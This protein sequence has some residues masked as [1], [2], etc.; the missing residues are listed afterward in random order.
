[1]SSLVRK[2]KATALFVS[3]LP[4]LIAVA[5][6]SALMLVSSVAAVPL[7]AFAQQSPAPA[8]ANATAAT[9]T[10]TTGTLNLKQ[11]AREFLNN[12][13]NTT[14]I[15]AAT[16][17]EDLV[18]NSTM[19]SGHLSEAQGSLVY[20]ITL[21][22]LA[23]QQ[24]YNIN[25]DPATGKVLSSPA[26]TTNTTATTGTPLSRVSSFGNITILVNSNLTLIDAAGIAESQIPNGMTLSASFEPALP[27]SSSPVYKIVVVDVANEVLYHV[28]VDGVTG[29]VTS[30]PTTT[31]LGNL[32]I[33]GL[34]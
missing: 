27:G 32:H 26:T 34:F 9:T 25:V 33:E 13:L 5:L 6:S 19:I 4:L 14:L 31:P 7:S 11:A 3:H 12:N 8:P 24:L 18:A 22:N 15:D 20:N 17:A 1:M 23:K 30:P 2:K 28:T 10:T 21:V 16:A 29:S